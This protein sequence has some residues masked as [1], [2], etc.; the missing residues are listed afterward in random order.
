MKSFC[1]YDEIICE[2]ASIKHDLLASFPLFFNDGL[3]GALL[4]KCF[5]HFKLRLRHS[6]FK[7]PVVLFCV[8]S[9]YQFRSIFSSGF[10]RPESVQTHCGIPIFYAERLLA[11]R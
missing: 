3:D 9:N 10:R 1:I 4:Q 2:P 5:E 8:T 11:W 6:N 7:R